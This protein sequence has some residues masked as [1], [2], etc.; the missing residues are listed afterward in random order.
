MTRDIKFRVWDIEF[1]EMISD[2]SIMINSKGELYCNYNIGKIKAFPSGTYKIMLFTGLIDKNNKEI[3][4]GDIVSCY[5]W[6]DG[7]QNKPKQK[8]NILVEIIP[9]TTIS[10]RV[11]GGYDGAD[12]YE[13]IEIIG[14]IF[15]NGDL[16]K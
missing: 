10:Y 11:S 16:L 13:D 14:N 1:K 15:E 5:H 4:E 6:F 3:Y 12:I 8:T 9:D 7:T 2:D